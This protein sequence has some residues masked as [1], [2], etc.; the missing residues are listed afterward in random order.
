MESDIIINKIRL[1]VTVRCQTSCPLTSSWYNYI[2]NLS[3]DTCVV[4]YDPAISWLKNYQTK[5]FPSLSTSTAIAQ[6][7]VIKRTWN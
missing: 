1:P 3:T 2:N 5:N 6:H 4:G 7:K